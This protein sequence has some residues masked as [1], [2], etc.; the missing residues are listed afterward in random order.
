MLHDDQ[1]EIL[2]AIETTELVDNT[3]GND[4]A[5]EN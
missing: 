4:K 3:A 2:E 5:V 1:K